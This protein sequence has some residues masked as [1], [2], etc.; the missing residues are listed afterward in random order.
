M[1][2]YEITI[3]YKAVITV[4]VRAGNE[5]NAKKIGLAEFTKNGR[6]SF[7]G[8]KVQLQYDNYKVDGCVDM[9]ATWNMYDSE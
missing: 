9:D 1:K 8:K 6:G 4:S 5:T 7:K 2:N 3:G